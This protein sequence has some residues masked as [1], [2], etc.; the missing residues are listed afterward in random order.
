MVKKITVFFIDFC[1]NIVYT[2]I[3]WGDMYGS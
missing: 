2:I 1:I 3:D